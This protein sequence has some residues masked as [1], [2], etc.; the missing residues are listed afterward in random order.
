MTKVTYDA[1]EV[2]HI[3]DTGTY[4]PCPDCGT[5]VDITRMLREGCRNCERDPWAFTVEPPELVECPEDEC[6]VR[7][8]R[9]ELVRHVRF[10][11]DVGS[12]HR[13]KQR[14]GGVS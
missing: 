4:I 13:A 5:D 14:V 7:R 11:H 3:V 1:D 12:R 6:S 10:D 8:P 9:E 2:E